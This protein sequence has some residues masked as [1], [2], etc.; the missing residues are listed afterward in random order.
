M[1]KQI[2]RN[3]STTFLSFIHAFNEDELIFPLVPVIEDIEMNQTL[4]LYLRAQSKVKIETNK[5]NSTI[6]MYKV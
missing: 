1:L 6:N 2:T 3:L 4:S 5:H